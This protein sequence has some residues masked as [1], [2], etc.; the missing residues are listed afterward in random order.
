MFKIFGSKSKAHSDLTIIPLD[1]LE[2]EKV[3]EEANVIVLNQFYKEEIQSIPTPQG[4]QSRIAKVPY[5]LIAKEKDETIASL[6]KQISVGSEN[7]A[8]YDRLKAEVEHLNSINHSLAQDMAPLKVE[9][10]DLQN[11]INY[12]KIVLGNDNFNNYMNTYE[13]NEARKKAEGKV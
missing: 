4:V 8:E 13:Q 11:R 9:N 3:Q 1:N 2:L 12:F 6:K 10:N 5:I 7:Y